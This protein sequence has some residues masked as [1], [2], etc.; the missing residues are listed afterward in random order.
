MQEHGSSSS[1]LCLDDKEYNQHARAIQRLVQELGVP[2]EIVN[3][4]YKEILDV[5]KKDAKVKS[6]LPILVSRSVKERLR[7]Q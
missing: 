2:A 5:L 3:R 6:F 1:I 7:G 4:S